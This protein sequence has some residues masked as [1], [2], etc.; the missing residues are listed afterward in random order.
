MIDG[1]TTRNRTLKA[2]IDYIDGKYDCD[3][4]IS[5]V[6]P[7]TLRYIGAQAFCNCKNVSEISIPQSVVSVGGSAFSDTAYSKINFV[8]VFKN[9][10]LLFLKLVFYALN[11]SFYFRLVRF[12]KRKFGKIDPSKFVWD[13]RNDSNM[14]V[15]LFASLYCFW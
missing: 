1:G 8:N 10:S 11:F 9:V 3:K 5:V 4:L 14:I 7:S 12:I 6:L 15:L 13:D 2:V